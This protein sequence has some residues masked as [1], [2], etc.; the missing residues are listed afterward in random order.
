MK[1]YTKINLVLIV[2]ISLLL[3]SVSI[4]C[5]KTPTEPEGTVSLDT[6]LI[7][8]QRIT[9]KIAFSSLTTTGT[10]GTQAFLFVIDG[11]SRKAK[12]LKVNDAVQFTNLTWSNDGL[13]LTYSQFD[14]S[15]PKWQLYNINSDGTNETAVFAAGNSYPSWSNDGRLAHWYNG[16]IWIGYS[17]FYSKSYCEQTRP[18]WSPDNKY[19]VIA[20]HDGIYRVSLADTSALQLI[21]G[22]YLSSPAYSP[23]GNKIA[24]VGTNSNGEIWTMNADGS[25]QLRLTQ[26]QEDFYPAWSPDGKQILFMR[27]VPEGFTRLFLMN[28]DGSQQV[29]IT[30]NSAGYPTWI[31]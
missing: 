6:N 9:G 5:K 29:Q 4:Q 24:F 21:K 12:L 22:S 2:I 15:N 18:S 11:D 17:L 28:S 23:D 1:M 31:Q 19:M 8:W 14:M 26:Y 16:Q 3:G 10:K 30:Q 27:L 7:P 25:N 20:M 13:K